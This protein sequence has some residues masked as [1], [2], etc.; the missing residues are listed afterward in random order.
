[1]IAGQKALARR[2]LVAT[3][4]QVVAFVG[5][6]IYR[7]F[8]GVAQGEGAGGQAEEILGARR[9]RAAEIRAG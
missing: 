9:F 4:P 5:V 2:I 8:F 6:S 1:M 7:R 3:R